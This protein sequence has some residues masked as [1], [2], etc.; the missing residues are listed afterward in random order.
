MKKKYADI[1]DAIE[2]ESDE[3]YDAM[4]LFGEYCEE[5]NIPSTS[6]RSQLH[7]LG[8]LN[9]DSDKISAINTTIL[10]SWKSISYAVDAILVPGKS[11]FTDTSKSTFVPKEF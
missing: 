7:Y 10:K 11:T 6:F 8:R 9:S 1:I 2:V 4:C 5:Q 3:L